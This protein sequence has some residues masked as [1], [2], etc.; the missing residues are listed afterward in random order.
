M[1]KALVL[2]FL[3]LRRGASLM[4]PMLAPAIFAGYGRAFGA[5]EFSPD[6]LGLIGKV[7][8]PP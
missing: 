1:D 4:E 5:S 6:P 8:I 3:V 7:C 2:R